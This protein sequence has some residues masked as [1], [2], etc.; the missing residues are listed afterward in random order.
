MKSKFVSILEK[1]ESEFFLQTNLNFIN[2]PS[3][4]ETFMTSFTQGLIMG[5]EATFKNN[6][7]GI[8]LTNLEA[9]HK[10]LN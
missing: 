9:M 3:S 8:F 6:V 2:V 10:N 7:F 5:L 4:Y 1:I